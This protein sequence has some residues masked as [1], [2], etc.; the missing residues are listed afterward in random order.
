MPGKRRKKNAQ[1][2]LCDNWSKF[3]GKNA[4]KPMWERA[5]SRKRWVIQP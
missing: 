5:C 4:A 3:G 2:G 1:L